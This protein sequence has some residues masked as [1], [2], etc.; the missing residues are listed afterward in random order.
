MFRLSLCSE[1][2]LN[3]VQTESMLGVDILNYV[4]TESML[5]VDILKYVQTESMLGDDTEICLD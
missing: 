3:Y 5:G 4:Q 2:T 1:M